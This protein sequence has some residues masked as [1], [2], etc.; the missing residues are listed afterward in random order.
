MIHFTG[1][2]EWEE[3]TLSRI[4]GKHVG[5]SCPAWFSDEK[6][7]SAGTDFTPLLRACTVAHGFSGTYF[8]TMDMAFPPIKRYGSLSHLRNVDYLHVGLI[9]LPLASTVWARLKN[10]AINQMSWYYPYWS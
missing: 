2:I 9:Q 4:Y 10:T 6:S 5:G 8:E 7:L 1:S 3:Y